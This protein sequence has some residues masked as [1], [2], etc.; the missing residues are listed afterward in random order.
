M[1]NVEVYIFGMSEIFD[2]FSIG[3]AYGVLM[4]G[5]AFLFGL[6]VAQAVKIIKLA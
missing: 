1:E 4:G 5:L 6:G 2:F 3:A